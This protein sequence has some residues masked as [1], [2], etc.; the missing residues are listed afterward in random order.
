MTLSP[1]ALWEAAL[2]STRPSMIAH[3]L[4]TRQSILAEWNCAPFAPLSEK[5]G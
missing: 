4:G 3:L 1:V 2:V 5:R